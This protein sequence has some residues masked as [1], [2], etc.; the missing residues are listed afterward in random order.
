MFRQEKHL[1][2]RIRGARMDNKPRHIRN[3][4]RNEWKKTRKTPIQLVMMLL[5]PFLTTMVLFFGLSYM[6]GLG[7]HYSGVVYLPTEAEMNT[8][9]GM[10]KERYSSFGHLYHRYPD[11][12]VLRFFDPDILA[13]AEGIFGYRI[14][15]VFP[16]SGSCH[17]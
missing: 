10:L 1:R 8:A 9:E 6:R 5:V 16:F 2:K 13:G 11:R 3:A 15:A 7:D 17:L 14:R 12:G 4:M